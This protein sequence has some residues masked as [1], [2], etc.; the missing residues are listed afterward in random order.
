MRPCD[1]ACGACGAAPPRSSSDPPSPRLAPVR[2]TQVSAWTLAALQALAAAA[3]CSYRLRLGASSALQAEEPLLELH[4]LGPQGVLLG[5]DARYHRLGFVSGQVRLK[6]PA[7]HLSLNCS[8]WRSR[9]SRATGHQG[10]LS[11]QADSCSDAR[12]HGDSCCLPGGAE[13]PA[14]PSATWSRSDSSSL[15]WVW[16]TEFFC[17]CMLQS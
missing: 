2:Q 17:C 9:S 4:Q 1:T 3:V 16:I 13:S 11:H 15:I 8:W 6:G 12:F 14:G 5:Q 10:S 7:A